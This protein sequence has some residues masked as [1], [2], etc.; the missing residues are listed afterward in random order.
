MTER[1]PSGAVTHRPR[2][3]PRGLRNQLRKLGYL[4]VRRNARHRFSDGLYTQSPI[5]AG[6]SYWL[7]IPK[8]KERFKPAP[9]IYRI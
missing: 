5:E 9:R 8:P 4:I 1:E 2:R 6:Q 3:W 7:I